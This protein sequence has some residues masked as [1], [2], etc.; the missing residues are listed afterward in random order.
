MEG[1]R[2]PAQRAG[3]ARGFELESSGRHQGHR[4]CYGQD[5]KATEHLGVV[6]D[7]PPLP[8]LRLPDG[9]GRVPSV[10][11]H[12]MDSARIF[13]AK[14]TLIALAMHAR[15]RGDMTRLRQRGSWQTVRSARHAS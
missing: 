12:Q 14:L 5:P 7:S 11:G 10:S 4:D 6:R 15:S 1:G 13:P 8:N 9:C 3:V 2:I